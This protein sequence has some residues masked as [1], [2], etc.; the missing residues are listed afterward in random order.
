MAF[1]LE[2]FG[3]GRESV[4]PSHEVGGEEIDGVGANSFI[5]LVHARPSSHGGIPIEVGEG[6]WGSF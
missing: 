4:F 2:D 1:D 6:R 5:V 3:R